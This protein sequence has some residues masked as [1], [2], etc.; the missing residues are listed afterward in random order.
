[1]KLNFDGIEFSRISMEDN[2]MLTSPFK[3]LEFKEA[4]WD[5]GGS[6]SPRSNGCN[7]NFLK[8]FW[9]TLKG[10]ILGFVQG[11]YANGVFPKGTNASFV[12]FIPK[13]DEPQ[14]LGE[15]RPISLVA[16]HV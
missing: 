9:G 11:F 6:K 7:F 1:M 10:D 13:V 14:G 15:Y 16:V 2:L 8:A 3:E 5:S 4:T 12:S